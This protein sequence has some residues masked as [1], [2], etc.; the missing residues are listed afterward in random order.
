MEWDGGSAGQCR[1][2]L[3]QRGLYRCAVCEKERT[4]RNLEKRHFAQTHGAQR[5][6]FLWRPWQENS[7]EMLVG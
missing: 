7:Q 6:R 2:S 5:E 4:S 1:R 3:H